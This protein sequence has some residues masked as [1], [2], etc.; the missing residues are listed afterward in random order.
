MQ[1]NL[2]EHLQILLQLGLDKKIDEIVHHQH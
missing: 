2:I 1:L